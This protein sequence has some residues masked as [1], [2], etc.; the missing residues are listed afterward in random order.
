MITNL[1]INPQLL[2][3]L[4]LHETKQATNSIDCARS[5]GSP[6]SRST[7]AEWS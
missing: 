2:N 1:K 3:Y 6:P 5:G 7:T 4:G